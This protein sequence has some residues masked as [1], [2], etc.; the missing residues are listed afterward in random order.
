LA[1]LSWLHFMDIGDRPAARPYWLDGLRSAEESGDDEILSLL[2]IRGAEQ[3]TYTERP[4]ESTKLAQQARLLMR[5][6]GSRTAVSWTFAMEAEA[7]AKAHEDS[8]CRWA[9]DAATTTLENARL[10]DSPAWA[11]GFSPARMAGYMGACFAEIGDA[12]GAQ[13]A[14]ERA[15][16]LSPAG[17]S[18]E[19]Y[20]SLYCTDLA[21]A[22]ARSNALDG[23]LESGTK[24]LSLMQTMPHGVAAERLRVLRRLVKELGS[25]LPA[26]AEFEERAVLL[27]MESQRDRG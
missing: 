9:L 15:S 11:R 21:L 20:R 19:K 12:K 10:D 1:L 13:L 3:L 6:S 4:F 23:A 2:M 26:A 18:G 14:C 8:A 24:A 17:S 5:K 22:Y 16:A 27:D 7:Y 25:G